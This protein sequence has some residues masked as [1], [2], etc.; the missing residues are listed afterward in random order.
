VL[1]M[2]EDDTLWKAI[3]LLDMCEC[4]QGTTEEAKE[5]T[6]GELREIIKQ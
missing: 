1:A 2:S 6:I 4:G 3:E 5:K